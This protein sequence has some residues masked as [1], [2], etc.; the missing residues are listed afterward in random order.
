MFS[1][2]YSENWYGD[3]CQSST[4]STKC[5]FFPSIL[6]FCLTLHSIALELFILFRITPLPRIFFS[7]DILPPA[8]PMLEGLASLLLQ[9]HVLS[10]SIPCILQVEI[11]LDFYTEHGFSPGGKELPF[12]I[13]GPV[14]SRLLLH[15]CL[16]SSHILEYSKM[17][18]GVRLISTF[19]FSCP[20]NFSIHRAS[21]HFF[22]S[23]NLDRF[24]W[25]QSSYGYIFRK[26]FTPSMDNRES[27]IEQGKH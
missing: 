1:E 6:S 8:S 27:E 13:P 9:R 19:P 22:E 11:R 26:I 20:L 10:P 23:Q 2:N 4:F 14:R 5:F 7:L 15:C 3:I 21:S 16:R 12:A 17:S 24:F 25:H 18:L